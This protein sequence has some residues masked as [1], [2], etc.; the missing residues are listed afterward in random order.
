MASHF[1]AA[2]PIA[3]VASGTWEQHPEVGELIL[4]HLS[5]KCPYIVPHYPA[6]KEGM[7]VE[8]YRRSMFTWLK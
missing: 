2:F 6:M 3:A 4:A 7:T 1:E 8:D 5:R